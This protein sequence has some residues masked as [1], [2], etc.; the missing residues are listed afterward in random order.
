MVRMRIELGGN[1]HGGTG[2]SSP[3]SF[4]FR[5]SYSSSS[6]T[7][8]DIFCCSGS[9]QLNHSSF[10]WN[11]QLC[12][13]ER[14]RQTSSASPLYIIFL[15]FV[16]INSVICNDINISQ[17]SVATSL[18]FVENFSDHFIALFDIDAFPSESGKSFN[19]C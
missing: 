13:R 3:G 18:R 11:T 4:S 9:R 7:S 17:V 8:G 16:H 15:Y 1:G 14:S 2:I 12:D 6:T 5:S 19:I 10:Y